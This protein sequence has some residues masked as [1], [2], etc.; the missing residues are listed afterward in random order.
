[1]GITSFS[2]QTS[3]EEH[4]PHFVRGET[5]AERP[6][7]LFKVTYTKFVST[8]YLN[9]VFIPVQQQGLS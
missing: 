5:E 8:V 6:S 4:V 9:F 2:P 1:M 7:N 3:Q